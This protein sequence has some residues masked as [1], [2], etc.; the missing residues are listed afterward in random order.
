MMRAVLP[1]PLKNFVLFNKAKSR[2]DAELIPIT[3]PALHKAA[4]VASDR[5]FIGGLLSCLR[6]WNPVIM[7]LTEW[8]ASRL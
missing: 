4:Y 6:K 8:I 1:M 2:L 3:Q 5:C 7:Y